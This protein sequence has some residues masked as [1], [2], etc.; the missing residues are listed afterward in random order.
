[1]SCRR[2]QDYKFGRIIIDGHTYTSDVIVHAQGVEPNW[3]RAH[4][5]ILGLEDLKPIY[6]QDPE[7]LVV[8]SGAFGMMV[9]AEET[10]GE[11]RRRN[12]QVVVERTEGACQIYSQMS[13][14][15]RAVAAL[16]LTC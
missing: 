4:V 7:V 14:L 5:H 1:M 15:V 3:W 6:D 12:I 9:V 10:L 8:G 2:I 16:H 13:S 11:L